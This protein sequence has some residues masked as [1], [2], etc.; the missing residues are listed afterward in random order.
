MLKIAA[1]YVKVGGNMV[2]STCTISKEEN[3]NV[4]NAFLEENK[5]FCLLAFEKDAPVSDNGK[6]YVQLM[7]HINNTDGFFIARM[8]KKGE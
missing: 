1:K 3:I 5:N 2:Y 7:P 4:V 8:I 6:G